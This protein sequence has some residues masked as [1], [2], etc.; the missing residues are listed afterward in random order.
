[1]ARRIHRQAPAGQLRAYLLTTAREFREQ[2]AHEPIIWA[3]LSLPV[4][5]LASGQEHRLHRYELPDDHPERWPA[6]DPHDQLELGTDDVL[7]PL[8]R[9]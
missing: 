5:A 2:Y 7:R 1:M 3:E 9:N 4:D 8:E 6:G